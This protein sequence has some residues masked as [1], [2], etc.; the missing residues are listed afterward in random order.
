[1]VVW[2]HLK[3]YVI[4]QLGDSLEDKWRDIGWMARCLRDYKGLN[5]RDGIRDDEENIWEGFR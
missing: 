1:M 3:P 2:L 5:Y 4:Y